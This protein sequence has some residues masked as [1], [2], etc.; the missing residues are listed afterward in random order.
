MCKIC[1]KK[2]FCKNLCSR[3]YQQIRRCGKI[4]KRTTKDKNEII[5]RGSYY[6]MVLYNNKSKEIARTIFSKNQLKKVK[7]YKWHLSGCGYASARI[8]GALVF[9]H[10]LILG[11]KEGFKTDHKDRNPLNN[12]N[13]NLRFA[14]KSQNAMNRNVMGI[15]WRKDR[16]KWQ[17]RIK[18]NYR[19]KHLGL[20]KRK[21]EALK[22]RKQAE[23]KYFGEFAYKYRERIK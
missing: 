15:H 17:A 19:I 16:K 22:A 5:D 6:E 2:V 12:L 7:K 13:N 4:L 21:S 1:E 8:S 3:H 11:K 20:F 18:I 23:L 9:L 14:N 10:Q